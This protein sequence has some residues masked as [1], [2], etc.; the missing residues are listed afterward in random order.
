MARTQGAELNCPSHDAKH[1]E[2]DQPYILIVDDDEV[3]IEDLMSIWNPPLPVYIARSG[4]AFTEVLE[5]RVSPILIILDVDLPHFFSEV[6]YEEG[7]A[8][9]RYIRERISSTMPVIIASHFSA[10]EIKDRAMK[11]GAQ[12]YFTK[13]FSVSDLE[14]AVIDLLKPAT[15]V[16]D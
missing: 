14:E 2:S 3:F 4:A 7:L 16:S 11:L 13:P 6:D 10:P 8:I 1:N 12:K 9:L 5:L 15:P